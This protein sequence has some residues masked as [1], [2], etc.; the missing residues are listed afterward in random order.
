MAIRWANVQVPIGSGM[1]QTTDTRLL[2]PGKV[3]SCMNG[4]FTKVGTVSKRCG[5]Q[6]YATGSLTSGSNTFTNRHTAVV[7]NTSIIPAI[8]QLSTFRDEMVA[9]DAS[10][11]YM[12]AL[13]PRANIWNQVDR[14]P[15]CSAKRETVAEATSNYACPDITYYNGYLIYTWVGQAATDSL[16]AYG[17]IYL[18]VVDAVTKVPVLKA[19]QVSSYGLNP[20]LQVVN[21]NVVLMF[22]DQEAPGLTQLQMYVLNGIG[23]NAIPKLYGPF[24][25]GSST[26]AVYFSFDLC[27]DG[28]LLYAAYSASLP[29]TTLIIDSIDPQD[30][31]NN[32]ATHD[33]LISTKTVNTGFVTRMY[34]VG[35][36]AI[37]FGG[38]V[39]H[40]AA[41]YSYQASTDCNVVVYEVACTAGTWGATIGGPTAV[42]SGDV[43]NGFQF[44]LHSGIAYRDTTH[45][46][47]TYNIELNEDAAPPGG[48][49]L[50]LNHRQARAQLLNMNGAAPMA[51]YPVRKN[52][53]VQTIS[54]PFW[55]TDPNV[56]GGYRAYVYAISAPTAVAP[57]NYL[58]QQGTEHVFDLGVHDTTSTVRVFMPVSTLA[59]RLSNTS[60]ANVYVSIG[61]QIGA[62]TNGL[63][64]Y[65]TLGQINQDPNT[66]DGRTGLQLVSLDFN[67]MTQYQTNVIGE[68]LHISAGVPMYYDGQATGDIGFAYYPP[69]QSNYFFMTASGGS[70]AAGTYQYALT[71]EWIDAR[72]QWHQS[73]PSIQAAVTTTAPASSVEMYITNL[74]ITNRNVIPVS[75]TNSFPQAVIWRSTVGGTV[76]H[77][78]TPEVGPAE[79]ICYPQSGSLWYRDTT[80]DGDTVTGLSTKEVLYTVG[81]VLANFN[82]PSSKLACSHVDRLWL[83]GQDNPKS[84]WYSQQT[85]E[86]LAM[87]FNDGLSFTVDA[88]GDIT[89]IIGLDERLIVFKSDR[90]FGVSGQGPNALGQQ[91]DLTTPIAIPSDVGTTQ[92]RSVVLTPD[93]IMFRSASTISMLTR[94]NEVINVG[95]PVVDLLAQYPNVTSAVVHPAQS[96]VRFTCT[97]NTLTTGSNYY[98]AGVTL[99]YDY[100][101]KAWTYFTITD[102]VHGV[103]SSAGT[104]A[105]MWNGQYAYASAQDFYKSGSTGGIFGENTTGLTGSFGDG[106][107]Y[108]DTTTE[109]A[110]MAT[111]DIQGCQRVKF[112]QIMGHGYDSCD[113]AITYATDYNPVYN[114]PTTFHL[115]GSMPN[116][117]YQIHVGDQ[118]S[119][120]IRIKVTDS[121]PTL[122]S[123]G[124]AATTGKGLK[125]VRVGLIAGI[126]DGMM[127]LP[128]GQT[129]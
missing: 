51:A 28:T 69:Q 103:T 59:P 17:G 112:I 14:V 23:A 64:T 53:W 24:A 11:H 117:S 115:S 120:S 37:A 40:V 34:S 126:K 43:A 129:S 31:I 121:K 57:T 89:A 80:G 105:I 98:T 97:A 7:G 1:D 20:K 82:P 5:Y 22:I 8:Q 74:T 87:S 65:Y 41:I 100:L 54:K 92:P 90:I 50:G 99:V 19:T 58:N 113:V 27:S 124:P 36:S 73:A 75:G 38:G 49:V 67:P 12:Y 68:N 2:S 30:A 88:G 86:G 66:V 106:G 118:K 101:A 128:P 119:E 114:T 84:I 109:S 42:Y 81:G 91:N 21:N 79:L 116:A 35:V 33:G 45:A 83:A 4:V 25:P 6:P 47:V 77:R 85:V 71:Y 78:L 102:S 29:N 52:W 10:S 39:T 72:G 18:M 15:S 16:I 122:A 123:Q 13:S 44:S 96:Q 76:M 93:G 127:K 32:G 94:G 61:Q 48:K 70:M 9:I 55:V 46:V 95:S 125:L 111:N 26:P 110:W 60:L 3:T 62:T 108:I 56:L 104:S 63:G 107:Y